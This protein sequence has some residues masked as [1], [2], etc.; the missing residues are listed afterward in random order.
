MRTFQSLLL[1][2]A[3]FAGLAHSQG[4]IQADIQKPKPDSWPTFNGDYS[5]RRYSPL[6]EINTEN[7]K[8]LTLKWMWSMPENGTMEITPLVHNGILFIWVQC[9]QP[10]QDQWVCID[11]LFWPFSCASPQPSEG[12][13]VFFP[14]CRE[15]PKMVYES[16]V[17][18]RLS[19]S[20]VGS[21]TNA[22]SP[23]P[24]LLSA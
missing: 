17:P 9:R 14:R 20:H 8:S 24:R 12:S 16:L 4:L 7:V 19:L 3:A 1:A 21:P 22:L 10:R 15:R 5:G 23:N 6:K 11:G 2:V 13:S 18:F